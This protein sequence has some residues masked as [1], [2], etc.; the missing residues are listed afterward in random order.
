MFA[1][2]EDRQLKLLLT[3]LPHCPFIKGDCDTSTE[4]PHHLCFLFP[5]LLF[6]FRICFSISEF[7]FLFP[8]FFFIS[9]FVF[10]F[11][12]SFSISEFLFLK[13]EFF[14]CF[15]ISFS[16]SEL[17]SFRFSGENPPGFLFFS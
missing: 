7:V 1:Q 17:E 14:F 8:N 9:D 15:R 5:N 12:I 6:Y 13:I 10:Y 4:N 16:I 11:R 2:K 3:P